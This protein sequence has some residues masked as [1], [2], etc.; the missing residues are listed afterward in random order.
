MVCYFIYFTVIRGCDLPGLDVTGLSDPY[1][2]L[3]LHPSTMFGHV[4]SQRTRIVEQTLNPVFNTSFQ[5]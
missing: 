3:S 1:V 4:K 2:I 5:L